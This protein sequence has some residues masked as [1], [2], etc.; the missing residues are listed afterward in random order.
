MPIYH[1]PHYTLI[2]LKFKGLQPKTSDYQIHTD[3]FLKKN[4]ILFQGY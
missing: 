1:H 3:I 2:K 4:L